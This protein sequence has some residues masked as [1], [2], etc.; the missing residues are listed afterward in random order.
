MRSLSLLWPAVALAIVS[1]AGPADAGGLTETLPR[2]TLLLDEAFYLSSLSHMY[3]NNGNLRPLIDDIERYEPGGGWQ[4][5]IVPDVFVRYGVLVSQLQYGVLDY[6]TLGIG[7]PLVVLNTVEPSLS[8]RPGS[9]QQSIGR[10]YS[11]DDFWAWAE[12]MG[13]PRPGNWSGNNGVLGDIVLGLRYRFTDHLP[14][15]REHEQAISLSVSGSLP[16]GSPPDPEEIVAAG[17]TSWDLHAQ[18]ELAFHLSYDRFFERNLDGRLILSFDI[19]YEFFF[20]HEYETPR[21]EQNPLLLNFEPYVGESYTIDPGDFFGGSLQLEVVPYRGPA[22]ATWLSGRNRE[23]AATLPPILSLYVRYTYVHLGQTDWESNSALWD[24]QRE[25]N[26]APGHK[27][28]L[29]AQLTVSLLRLGAPLQLY[30]R[31]R[32][33]TWIAGRNSRAANTWIVGLKVPVQ[34][35]RNRS[36]EDDSDVDS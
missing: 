35:G 25:Q 13:Q 19:F 28:I 8:W 36:S 12:S 5:T 3:D 4:G 33:L 29:T 14:W 20:R 21:G 15:F 18:G 26:W 30:V 2:G 31:Y 7:V 11:G 1:A 24:W 32:N 22:L 27:N 9:Y 10:V 23:R 34:F 16:T 17:T 6:L